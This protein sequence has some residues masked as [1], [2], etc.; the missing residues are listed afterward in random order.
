MGC[1]Y[2]VEQFH[3]RYLLWLF[4]FTSYLAAIGYQGTELYR[5]RLETLTESVITIRRLQ[6]YVITILRDYNTTV[7]L[8]TFFYMQFGLF[9]IY[10]ASS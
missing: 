1:D 3:A 9:V 5:E 10:S 4:R 8:R 7:G 6:H 2:S